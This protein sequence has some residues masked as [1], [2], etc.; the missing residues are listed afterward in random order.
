MGQALASRGGRALGIAHDVTER[1][2]AEDELRQRKPIPQSIFE[3]RP[4][5]MPSWGQALPAQDIW[6]LVAFIQS[7]GGS[8]AAGDRKDSLNGDH[9]VTSVAPEV[10]TIEPTFN[11]PALRDLGNK[12]TD[13]SSNGGNPTPAS[14]D[15]P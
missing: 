11:L 8:Y 12:A 14:G 7:Y 10:T 15:A 2:I 9:G 13:A 5:G 4:Q 1:K 3:G 6:K